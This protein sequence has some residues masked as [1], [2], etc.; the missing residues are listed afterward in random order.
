MTEKIQCPKDELIVLANSLDEIVFSLMNE[1][2]VKKEVEEV[3]LKDNP[4][5]TR[6]DVERLYHF[7]LK[8]DEESAKIMAKLYAYGATREEMIDTLREHVLTCERC[9][10]AYIKEVKEAADLDMRIA[11]KFRQ[12]PDAMIR[13]F[14]RNVLKA[15][16]EELEKIHDSLRIVHYRDSD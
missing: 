9:C 5:A 1:D 3:V 8:D 14:G 6:G 16:R 11:K 10:D 13:D 7:C 12:R 4:N 2:V 15:D